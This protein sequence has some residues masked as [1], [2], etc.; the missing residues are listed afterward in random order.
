MKNPAVVDDVRA[1]GDAQRFAHVV[2]RNQ[3]ADAAVLQMKD[4]FL[5]IGDGDRIDAGER[6]VEQEEF[7]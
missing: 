5:N 3:H 1:V 4:D 6:L 2:V 7:W